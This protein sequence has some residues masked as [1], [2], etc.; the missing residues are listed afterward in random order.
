VLYEEVYVSPADGILYTYDDLMGI[1]NLPR[2]KQIFCSFLAE[3][4]HLIL[5]QRGFILVPLELTQHSHIYI[6]IDASLSPT[7]DS[8][9]IT[10]LYVLNKKNPI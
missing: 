7:F 10:N 2:A 5:L 9:I 4:H 6:Y 1:V 3:L 8:T